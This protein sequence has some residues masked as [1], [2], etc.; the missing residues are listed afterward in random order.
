MQAIV[1]EFERI[2]LP[3]SDMP[4]LAM[5]AGAEH[6]LLEHLR[7][8]PAGATWRDVFPDLPADWSPER[9]REALGRDW[10]EPV[11]PFDDLAP[12]GAVIVAHGEP[13][14]LGPA[15]ASVVAEFRAQGFPLHSAG[16]VRSDAHG[17]SGGVA[18]EPDASPEVIDTAA[19]WLGTR[20]GVW[21]LWIPR[22]GYD[23]AAYLATLPRI[24][25]PPP[26]FPPAI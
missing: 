15:W 16:I 26:P 10:P 3:L 19:H 6:G 12:R 5:E 1:A 9:A 2:G 25:E 13:A 11:G 14:V 24:P 7:R 8:L 21:N 18:L 17:F 20:P 22:F 23:R 4:G